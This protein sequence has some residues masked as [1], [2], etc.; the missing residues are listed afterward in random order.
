MNITRDE[1]LNDL[2]TLPAAIAAAEGA[3]LEAAADLE[4]HEARLI[5]AGAVNGKNE[6]ERKAQLTEAC[7]DRRRE[8]DQARV[9]LHELQARFA[10][11]RAASRLLEAAE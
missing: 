2:R 4:L 6:M 11:R 5:L 7:A 10:A 1:I 8:V 3:Y 9:A